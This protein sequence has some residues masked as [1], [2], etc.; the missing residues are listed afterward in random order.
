MLESGLEPNGHWSIYRILSHW[1]LLVS[2]S[3]VWLVVSPCSLDRD[4]LYFFYELQPIFNTI[5]LA[6]KNFYLVL[7]RAFFSFPSLIIRNWRPWSLTYREW[8]CMV[9][10]FYFLIWDMDKSKMGWD[11]NNWRFWH[12][13]LMCPYGH[14]FQ[15]DGPTFGME[16]SP[17]R[18]RECGA[19]VGIITSFKATAV[20]ENS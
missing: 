2:N 18:S 19:C 17:K 7:I 3:N 1:R 12:P 20:V 4:H 8:D 16:K 13:N 9:F 14:T 5:I 15:V 6:S 11:M 10:K